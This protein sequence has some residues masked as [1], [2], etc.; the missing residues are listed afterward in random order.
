MSFPEAKDA[1][2]LEK[3]IL[4]VTWPAEADCSPSRNKVIKG[5][6]S[7]FPNGLFRLF[8]IHMQCQY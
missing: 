2:G 8:S 7:L 4:F 1:Y 6:L 3:P 5:Y